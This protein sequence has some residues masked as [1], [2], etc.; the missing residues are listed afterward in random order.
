MPEKPLFRAA[1]PILFTEGEYSDYGHVGLFVALTDLTATML[2][3]AREV[4]QNE[5]DDDNWFDDRER[6]IAEIIRRGWVM[7]VTV[8]EHHLGSYGECEAFTV[9]AD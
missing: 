9:A 6:F 5:K 8:D 3:E 7:A 2:N 1:H 4:S